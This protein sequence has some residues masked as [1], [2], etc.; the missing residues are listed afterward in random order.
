M[1]FQIV[2]ALLVFLSVYV[3]ISLE[4][5]N[6]ASIV[7]LGA[8]IILL[9]GIITPEE[10]FL[11]VNLHIIFLLTS[12]MVLVNIAKDTGLFQYIA[13]KAAKQVHGDPIKILI[14][15]SI[16]T[17]ITSAF[18]DNVTTIIIL[19]PIAILIS[20][21]LGI[22]PVP[23]IITMVIASNIGGT[24]T[25]IGDP[26]NIMIGYNAGLSFGDFLYNLTPLIFIIGAVGI[27]L[28]IAIFKNKLKATADRRAR[29][30]S[31]DETGI[32]TDKV[33]L[34][35]TLTVW[36]FVIL[37]FLLQDIFHISPSVIAMSG[38]VVL[39]IITGSNPDKYLA[40]IEWVTIF[41]FVGLFILVG[42]LEE[43][44][45]IEYIGQK[46]IVFSRDNLM[47][48]TF[49]ILWGGGVLSGIVDNIPFVAAMIPLI[50]MMNT[51]VVHT[52]S[53]ILWWSLSAGA[54]LGG[55]FT[56]IGASA[57]VVASQISTKSGFPV[58]F[59]DFTKYGILYTLVSLIIS[60]I[61]LYIRYF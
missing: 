19:S 16:L 49:T 45:I 18:L 26:P 37:G 33:M 34:I 39:L 32:I 57:N 21:E 17:G 5:V 15:L 22:S 14:F 50:D 46:L 41:F 42:T 29:I 23:Y 1:T 6:K 54:C 30:M 13:I 24:A 8:S 48:T 59:W 9:L 20:V 2:T 11:K 25:L 60:T 28:S 40:E 36:G 58:R 53:N 43:L 56:L 3:V 47:V 61:Y 4:L 55:N 44:K 52:G 27:A 10:A 51:S 31:F 35:K 7:I 12:L 38:A